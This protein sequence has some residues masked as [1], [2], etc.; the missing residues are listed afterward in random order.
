MDIQR[1]K[2]LLDICVLSV[3]SREPSYG[4]KIVGDVSACIDI[5]ESTLYPILKRLESAGCL[6]TF[7]QEHNGRMPKYYRITETGLERIRG[8]L[9]E[10]EEMRRVYAFIESNGRNGRLP[11]PGDAF[12]TT[13]KDGES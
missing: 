7:S 10:W 6:T 1:K 13:G 9:D 4:Y 3:L 12:I 8:F 5:S 11:L 2:G